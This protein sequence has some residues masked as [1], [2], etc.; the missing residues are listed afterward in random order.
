MMPVVTSKTE[1]KKIMDAAV[2]KGVSLAIFCTA[3]HWNTEAVLIAADRVAKRY[4][5][6]DI[7]VVVAMTFKYKY[8]QQSA[9]ILRCGDPVSGFLSVMEHLKI[10]CGG[11]KSPYS[12]VTVL[13]HLDHCDPEEDRWALTEGAPHVASVMFD[14]QKYP[15]EENICRT[16]EYVD[17][18]GK[19]VLVEGIIEELNVNESVKKN[20]KQSHDDNYIGRALEYIK[21]TGVDFLVA[22]LGTE[23]QSSATGRTVYNRERA[24][25]L[26]KQLGRPMLVLH[27]TSCLDNSEIAGLSGDGVVRVNMWT[28][29]AREAGQEAAERVLER[30]DR[31][32]MGDFEACESKQYLYDS[33]DKA[34]E[35]MVG[36]ME[37]LGYSKLAGTN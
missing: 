33:I 22:D 26:T 27:G 25:T 30:L 15:Y 4:S 1:A 28:R 6:Q 14:A 35:I 23:Q 16:K 18:Y 10:L 31:I 34:A 7:P 5:I 2:S 32:R 13:P 21:H 9:R 24:R 12:N 3:S 11:G 8:M 17:T 36:I 37:L 20:K 29:I 19:D